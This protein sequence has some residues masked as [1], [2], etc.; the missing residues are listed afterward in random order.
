MRQALQETKAFTQYHD[1]AFGV[2]GK[3]SIWFLAV[4][5]STTRIHIHVLAHN[6]AI[7]RIFLIVSVV[8]LLLLYTAS[9]YIY[10]II[11]TVLS[12]YK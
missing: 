3:D 7:P 5:Q 8:P 9:T 2:S 12:Y 11:I 6:R 4:F 1:A 10:H